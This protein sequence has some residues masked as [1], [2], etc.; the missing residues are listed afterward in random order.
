MTE[1]HHDANAGKPDLNHRVQA[2]LEMMRP[3]I[4]EDDGDIELVEVTHEGVVKIRFKG[5]CVGCPSSANTLHN[6]IERT[7]KQRV[8]E[9]IGVEAVEDPGNSKKT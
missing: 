4:Q 3:M 5:A 2:V 9:V 6:G 1:Q 7:L 8:P